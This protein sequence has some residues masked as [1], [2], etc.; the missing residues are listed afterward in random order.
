MGPTWGPPGADRTSWAPCWPREPC[1]QVCHY[2]INTHDFNLI[3]GYAT[4]SAHLLYMSITLHIEI[5]MNFLNFILYSWKMCYILM[6]WKSFPYCWPFVRGLNRC[7]LDAPETASYAELLK[8]L[9]TSRE[10]Q[11]SDWGR[12]NAYMM[13]QWLSHVQPCSTI[14]QNL[15]VN[16]CQIW[17]SN[18]FNIY[19]CEV[20][21]SI[22]L[23]IFVL[24]WL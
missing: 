6:T 5:R 13:S 9:F 23:F 15:N 19:D 7:L 4:I 10:F 3:T 11:A 12:L 22:I 17:N 18:P 2:F 21:S 14:S 24:L 1:Y 20:C 16:F 8:V